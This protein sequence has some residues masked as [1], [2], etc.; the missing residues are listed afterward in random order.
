MKRL[1]NIIT[2]TILSFIL[3][4]CIKYDMDIDNEL[5]PSEDATEQ[6]TDSLLETIVKDVL[7]EDEVKICNYAFSV[8]SGYEVKHTDNK[9]YIIDTENNDEE[10]IIDVISS[11]NIIKSINDVD[12]T[13]KYIQDS[14]LDG[15]V[16]QSIDSQNNIYTNSIDCDNKNY[17]NEF[18]VND[19]R[20]NKHKNIA[21]VISFIGTKNQVFINDVNGYNSDVFETIVGEITGITEEVEKAIDKIEGYY[22]IKTDTIYENKNGKI[23]LIPYTSDDKDIYCHIYAISSDDQH[24]T[25][26]SKD[27]TVSEYTIARAS[28]KYS[29]SYFLEICDGDKFYTDKTC[30]IKF[31]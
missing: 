9:V 21:V 29:D 8:P 26:V 5:M 22:I 13:I 12:S 23:E 6:A 27:G 19:K 24:I 14:I 28:N 11:N 7:T 30:V 20:T 25:K 15:D 2:I 31:N 4:S 17:K 3:T 16:L 1:L 18:W 10:V